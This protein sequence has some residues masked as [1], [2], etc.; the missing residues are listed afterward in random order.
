MNKISF[1]ALALAACTVGAPVFAQ[2]SVT[3]FGVVDLAVRSVKNNDRQSQLA[4]SGLT[5]SRLGFRGV[6]DLG[7]GLKANFWLEGALDPDTGNATGQTWQRRATVGLQGGF[8]EIRLGREKNPSGLTWEQLDPF[9]D[10]GMGA[11][12]RLQLANGMVPTGGAY[13]SYPRSSNAIA[14]YTP[15]S[16]FF[17]SAM[18]AAG[19][20]ALGNRHVGAR[21]GY[22]AGNLFAVLAYGTT[23][24]TGGVDLDR[25]TV[26]LTYDLKVVKLYGMF[27]KSDAGP[28]EQDNYLVGVQVPLGA[29]VLRASYHQMEGGGS[30]GNREAKQLNLGGQYNLSRRTALYANVADISNTNTALTVATGSTL[31]TGRD[32]S[33]FEIGLRHAF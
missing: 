12:G 5:S 33:G 32:S 11:V 14:Y 19:E 4:G 3:V 10:T 8:G 21:V 30:I 24:L 29:F 18:Y 22:G 9:A 1:A 6:E 13:A 7:G 16:G 15:G 26:G 23:E 25:V 20:G 27:S 28:A 17:A 2:S 31:S